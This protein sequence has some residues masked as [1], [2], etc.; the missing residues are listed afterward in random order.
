VDKWNDDTKR[1]L[2]CDDSGLFRRRVIVAL[3]VEHDIEVMAEC[4]DAEQSIRVA[5]DLA[6]DVVFVGMQLAQIGGVRTTAGLREV[7]PNARIVVVLEPEDLSDASR[8]V[9]AG[10]VGFL[11]RDAAVPRAVFATRQVADGRV[12]LPPEVADQVLGDFDSLLERSDV[13]GLRPPVLADRERFALDQL[14]DGV[15]EDVSAASS[16]ID[17]ATLHN[18]AASA[19]QKLHR[20]ARSEAVLYTVADR[21]YSA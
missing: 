11:S 19:V 20:F 1:V 14:R 9:R 4:D 7:I 17:A 15:T 16:G 13:P 12:L 21:V 18:L 6:P 10:A 2:V 5:R 3:E 8:A